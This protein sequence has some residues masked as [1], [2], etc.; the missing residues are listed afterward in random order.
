MIA[1]R[2]AACSRATH[3][4]GST[5]ITR[6]SFIDVVTKIFGNAV[7]GVPSGHRAPPSPGAGAFSYGVYVFM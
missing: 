6:E 7:T 2:P 1:S 3:L 5:T 4:S